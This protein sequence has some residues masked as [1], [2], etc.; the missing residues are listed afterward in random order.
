MSNFTLEKEDLELG[1]V[2]PNN[3]KVKDESIK[4]S[5]AAKEKLP[6]VHFENSSSLSKD[7][8]LLASMPELY[9]VHFVVGR[10]K[11]PVGAVKAILAARSR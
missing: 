4:E 5:N 3:N 6:S 9:D 8:G 7:L 11:Q 1:N 10:T 2:K